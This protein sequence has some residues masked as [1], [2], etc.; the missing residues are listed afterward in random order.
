MKPT[1]QSTKLTQLTR[2]ALSRGDYER[3][4]ELFA[5][6]RIGQPTRRA[7]HQGAKRAPPRSALTPAQVTAAT[8]A[9]FFPRS[10]LPAWPWPQEGGAP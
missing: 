2:A 9:S 4:G 5:L 3:A 8:R 6:A 7:L 10:A 1:L